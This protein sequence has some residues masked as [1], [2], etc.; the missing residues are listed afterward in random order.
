MMEEDRAGKYLTFKLAAEEYGLE[1]LRVREII[2][3]M[4][5]TEVPQT[6][7][8][9]RG[10]IN[11]RGSVIPVMDLRLKFGMETTADT[12]QTC[13]IVVEI[14][15]GDKSIATGLVVDS[16]SEVLDIAGD[17]IEDSPSFG[18]DI[19]TNYILGIGKI[20]EMVKILLNIDKVLDDDKTIIKGITKKKKE[21]AE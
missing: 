19:D 21:K 8:Y 12:D 15:S 20:G 4:D 11:L 1:I 14:N 13:V 3:L 2:G 16:V 7:Y 18:S 6:P 5:I 10:I 17:Q 9:I